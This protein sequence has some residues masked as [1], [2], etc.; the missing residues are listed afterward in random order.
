MQLT[1]DNQ[2]SYAGFIA[3]DPRCSPEEL[4]LKNYRKVRQLRGLILD[5]CDDSTSLATA[6][7]KMLHSAG[8]EVRYQPIPETSPTIPGGL[9]NGFVMQAILA[10]YCSHR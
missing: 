8:L 7:A 5:R 4:S 10:S 2:F 9:M 3:T 6:L 1:L